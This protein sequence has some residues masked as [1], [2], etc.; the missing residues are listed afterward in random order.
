VVFIR[1]SHLTL[2]ADALLLT[3]Y[4][5]L[6]LALGG[7]VLWLLG[8]IL[9]RVVGGCRT[10]PVWIVPASAIFLGPEIWWIET[11]RPI[12]LSD[13]TFFVASLAWLAASVV[14]G[15]L[16]VKAFGWADRF[17]P[18]RRWQRVLGVVL[19]AVGI[20]VGGYVGWARPQAVTEAEA[21]EPIEVVSTGTRVILLGVDAAT[22]D[23]MDP[24]IEKGGLPNFRRL[25][26][27]GS[28]GILQS[29]PSKLQ[30][31]ANSSS[32]GMRSGPLWT[33]ILTGR[34]P[35]EHGIEDFLVTYLPGMKGYIPFR[36]PGPGG[37]MLGRTLATTSS[38]RK[39]KALWNILGDGGKTTVV[40]GFWNTY[41]AEAVNGAMVSSV[42]LVRRTGPSRMYPEAV[43]ESVGVRPQNP[44]R[45]RIFGAW[46]DSLSEGRGERTNDALL[47]RVYRFYRQD[48][49]FADLGM[50]LNE[51]YDPQFLAV[52]FEGIDAFGHNLWK[53]MEP[54]RFPNVSP[55]D[56]RRYGSA[57]TNYY[58]FIDEL[59]GRY[60]GLVDDHT[61]LIVVS[62]HGFGPWR[63]PGILPD[64]PGQDY[65]ASFSGA[66]R[67]N[68]IIAVFGKGVRKG[69]YVEGATILDVTPTILATMGFPVSEELD[70]R[71][72]T[73][74]FLPE[75][76]RENP[77][78]RIR[79]Y[80]QGDRRPGD[81]GSE[82]S[83][84]VEQKEML[85][86]LGYIK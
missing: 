47:E 55:Q 80:G 72:L 5:C 42:A 52:Y 46:V 62:D 56:V 69:A 82:R 8:G 78:R 27:E 18:G 36:I 32:M 6:P 43:A 14:A 71:V 75:V 64:F 85:R 33:S 39:A 1:I 86:S 23:L 79:T 54:E 28:W 35:E 29:L 40:V 73:S 61:I 70:G 37:S 3:A 17:L 20:W 51:K 24:M 60:L 7:G 45:G 13:V 77:I 68:G 67:K 74:A 31:F 25:R 49:Y 11:H 22:W 26:E 76:F 44:D 34:T 15:L 50:R 9:S 58:E 2:L 53:Y 16:V 10:I 57:L 81:T 66:H 41:P 38:M 21:R 83:F 4:V 59:L 65:H 84:D 63:Q 12:F 30:P 19:G 48:A